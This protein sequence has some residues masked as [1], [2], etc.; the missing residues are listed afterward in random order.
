MDDGHRSV[1][2]QLSCFAWEQTEFPGGIKLKMNL[3]LKC[4][5]CLTFSLSPFS[6]STPSLLSPGIISSIKLLHMGP[7]LRVC[8]RGAQPRNLVL[9]GRLTA[10]LALNSTEE[11][12]YAGLDKVWSWGLQSKVCGALMMEV[13]IITREGRGWQWNE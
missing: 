11:A 2:A 6:L 5:P 8:L 7:C 4:H 9:G 12:G 10:F 1:K 13:Q 3:C